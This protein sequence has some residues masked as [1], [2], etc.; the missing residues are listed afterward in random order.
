IIPPKK[1]KC[2]EKTP[3]PLHKTF[4]NMCSENP[5]CVPCQSPHNPK[6][7]VISARVSTTKENEEE[8]EE[9]YDDSGFAM[10]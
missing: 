8:E 9:E 1:D 3:D 4:V 7:C 2:N 6:Y 5:W 10:T